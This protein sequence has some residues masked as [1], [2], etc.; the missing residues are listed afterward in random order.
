MAETVDE[1]SP[2]DDESDKDGGDGCGCGCLF[3]FLLA[4]ALIY[5]GVCSAPR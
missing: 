1:P 3:G 5:L 4:F 2:D